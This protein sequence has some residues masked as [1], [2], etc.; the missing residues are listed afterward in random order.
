[1]AGSFKNI[2]VEDEGGAVFHMANAD[3]MW[4]KCENVD[5]VNVRANGFGGVFW[6]DNLLKV[7]AIDCDA[8]D[9][10]AGALGTKGR[11]FYS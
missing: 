9:I 4:F 3:Q 11:F 1:M 7:Q 5:F 8:T 6:A 10:H 2:I